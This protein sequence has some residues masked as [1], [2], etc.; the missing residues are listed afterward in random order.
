MDWTKA[1]SHP[2]PGAC[3]TL[4]ALP[5]AFARVRKAGRGVV[6]LFERVGEGGIGMSKEAKGGAREERRGG[7]PENLLSPSGPLDQRFFGKQSKQ[8][9]YDVKD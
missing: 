4:P 3:T 7:K 6:H 1:T 9:N 2:L 5:R 8:E